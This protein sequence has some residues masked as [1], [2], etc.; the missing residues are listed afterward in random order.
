[1]QWRNIKQEGG[2]KFAFHSI[3]SFT[4]VTIEQMS[5]KGESDTDI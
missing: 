1:M 2:K 4:E 3:R 5:E